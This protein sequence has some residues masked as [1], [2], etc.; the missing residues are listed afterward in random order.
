M[1]GG[2]EIG[3]E[4]ALELSCHRTPHQHQ[5]VDGEKRI[6]S[7]FRDVVATEKALRLERLILG[8]VLDSP[9][10]LGGRRIVGGLVDGAEQHRHVLEFDS[11]TPFDAGKGEFSK[12]RIGAAEIE[13]KFNSHGT[14]SFTR[15]VVSGTSRP[16]PAFSGRY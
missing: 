5:R 8:L 10:G 13:L 7:K 15:Y 12:I 4:Q 3:F 2:A 11:G 16:Q 1:I 6:L 9:Q 14:F